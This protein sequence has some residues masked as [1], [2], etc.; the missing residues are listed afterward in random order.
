MEYYPLKDTAV[1]QYWKLRVTNGRLHLEENSQAE[2]QDNP[3]INDKDGTTWILSVD[4]GRLALTDTTPQPDTQFYLHDPTGDVWR[5]I[6]DHG[7]IGIEKVY[8]KAQPVLQLSYSPLDVRSGKWTDLSRF[9]NHGTPHGNARPFQIAPGMMGY[10]F[11]GSSGYV[12]VLHDNSLNISNAVTIGVWLKHFSRTDSNPRIVVKQPVNKAYLMWFDD[13]NSQIGFRI[14][15]ESDLTHNS[16]FVSHIPDSLWY[17]FVGT[18]DGTDIKIY[19][20]AILKD[21]VNFPGVIHVTDG[22]LVI[23]GEQDGSQQ[24]HGLIAQPIIENRAWS[25]DEV[26]ENM[27]CSPIYRMLRGLPHSFI[28]TKVPWKQTQGGIYVPL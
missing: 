27:Y 16:A 17:Y 19:K 20:N 25:P 23:G 15:R 18:Y 28:Y 7:V 11:D 2:Y 10:W 12:E 22:N 24:I 3:I 9:G 13:A 4:N 21:T 26:R 6:A 8:G 1:E 14:K 5:V